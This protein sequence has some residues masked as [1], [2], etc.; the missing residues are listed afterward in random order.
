VTAQPLA[1]VIPS[2]AVTAGRQ[3]A[4][5]AAG[6]PLPLARPE[7]VPSAL[8]DVAYGIGRID[9]S[10][11]I[12]DRA[13]T[14]ALGWNG[15]G[16][17]PGPH[18]ARGRR[19]SRPRTARRSRTSHSHA[20]TAL[21]APA[22][23][24]PA[25]PQSAGPDRHRAPPAGPDRRAAPARRPRRGRLPGTCPSCR[26]AGHRPRPAYRPRARRSRAASLPAGSTQPRGHRLERGA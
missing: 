13:V 7:P 2:S 26:G 14:T 11:R 4:R 8:E 24:G 17:R 5:S 18:A 21:P 19:S 10:G 25:R 9:A 12:A 16:D 6:R 22:T 1:P 23:R 3:R 20:S 15:G